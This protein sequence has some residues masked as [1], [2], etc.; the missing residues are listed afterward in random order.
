MSGTLQ[1]KVAVITGGASGMGLA[2]VERFIA[3]G[4]RV[5]F[6]DLP[7]QSET[8]LE[9]RLGQIKAKMHRGGRQKGG[10]S[11]GWAIADRLGHAAH[12]VAADI[13]ERNNLELVFQTAVDRF[14]GV[15]IVFNNAGVIASEGTI[16]DCPDAIFDHTIA[17]N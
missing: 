12:F 17:V 4:A 10:K 11:D 3:E 8:A 16:V 9:K 7:P 5:V 1:S 13:T 2:T 15:D 14:G 6:C